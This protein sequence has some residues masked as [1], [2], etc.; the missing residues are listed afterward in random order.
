MFGRLFLWEAVWEEVWEEVGGGIVLEEASG[1]LV[2]RAVTGLWL[3]CWLGSF[4]RFG[5]VVVVKVVVMEVEG[6]GEVGA[7]GC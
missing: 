1:W 2:G 5:E 3:G 6:S 4:G 7:E